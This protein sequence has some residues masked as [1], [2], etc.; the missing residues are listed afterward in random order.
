MEK[1]KIIPSFKIEYFGGIA[2]R[3]V[4]FSLRDFLKFQNPTIYPTNKYQLRK[5]KNFFN[6]L[7]KGCFITSF[8]D[9]YFQ[10]LVAIP[11]V[12]YEICPKQKCW[13][14][15]VFIVEELFS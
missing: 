14:G 1:L 8:T 11:R 7:Q 6:R 15:K 2:Y 3:E 4:I 12:K 10:S 13:I 5:L 9:S